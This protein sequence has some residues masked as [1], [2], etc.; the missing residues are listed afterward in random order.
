MVRLQGRSS[1]LN[2]QNCQVARMCLR[3]VNMMADSLMIVTESGCLSK[4]P[5]TVGPKMRLRACCAMKEGLIDPDAVRMIDPDSVSASG[6]IET[7]QFHHA[8]PARILALL[9]KTQ[10][11]P[12]NGKCHCKRLCNGKHHSKISNQIDL[13]PVDGFKPAILR[14]AVL[15]GAARYQVTSSETAEPLCRCLTICAF[16][17]SISI[18]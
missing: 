11:L 16:T 12:Q 8:L 4:F 3:S 7:P 10:L 18:N 5:T 14:R 6:S 1:E 9:K 13:G 15:L 2:F 17:S